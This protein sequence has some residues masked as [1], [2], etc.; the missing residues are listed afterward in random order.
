MV[1]QDQPMRR[2]TIDTLRHAA[3]VIRQ[4]D[5]T[6]PSLENLKFAVMHCVNGGQEF[7]STGRCRVSDVQYFKPGFFEDLDQLVW[8]AIGERAEQDG[9]DDRKDGGVGVD[10]ESQSDDGDES[11][12]GIFQHD[13]EGV[14]KVVE[15]DVHEAPVCRQDGLAA[16]IAW[17]DAAD[18]E[19]YEQLRLS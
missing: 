1:Y 14:A 7:L 15:E 5:A 4:S 2:Q 13:A 18:A 10:A 17:L 16:K 6:N 11:E 8:I 3:V 9:V 12:R 19:S